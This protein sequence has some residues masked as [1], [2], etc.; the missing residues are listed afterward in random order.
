VPDV[1]QRIT[2]EVIGLESHQQRIEQPLDPARRC[3]RVP[4]TCS[5]NSL[6]PFITVLGIQFGY[7]LG[8]A[9][10][11]EQIF[12]LPGLGRLVI[13]G[14]ESR[15]FPVVQGIVLAVATGFVLVN[16]IVD[17]LYSLLDP[18]IRLGGRPAR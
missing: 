1:V 14:I 11:I 5:A 3:D 2:Q 17:V 12:A 6:I 9:V 13:N 16:L 4:A 8:G 18:R 7:L 10:I 15:D